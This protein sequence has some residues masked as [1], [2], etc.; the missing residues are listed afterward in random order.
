MKTSA[1][2]H[3]NRENR[4][5]TCAQPKIPVMGSAP[6][7]GLGQ[8]VIWGTCSELWVSGHTPLGQAPCKQGEQRITF[9][10]HKPKRS[11]WWGFGSTAPLTSPVMPVG[12]RWEHLEGTQLGHVMGVPARDA[13]KRAG[14]ERGGNGARPEQP[15]E[16]RKCGQ[17]F[18]SAGPNT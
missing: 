6:T 12:V 5:D 14:G 18:L 17:L 9:Q 15:R 7:S 4:Q 10:P 11:C 13:K 2:K 1:P 3:S 16:A 8:Q